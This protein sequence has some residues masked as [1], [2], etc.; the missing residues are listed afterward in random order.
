MI[1][2]TIGFTQKTAEKFFE[3]IKINNIDILIDIRLNNTSQLSGFSR[4]P[5]IEFFLKNICD[6]NYYYAKDFAPPRDLL[7]S[8]REKKILWKDYEHFYLKEITNYEKNGSVSKLINFLSRYNKPCFLCSEASPA[9]CHRRIL[10]EYLLGK[11]KNSEIIH[12]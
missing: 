1:I 11:I 5:D 10:A 4:Y 2:Y 9:H 12:L 3:L 6:S 8:Y 7:K